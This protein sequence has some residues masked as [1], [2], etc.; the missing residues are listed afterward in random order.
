MDKK[1]KV[2]FPK[3]SIDESVAFVKK[4]DSK[5]SGRAASYDEVC[6]MLGAKASSST[7]FY[8]PVSSAR[9]FGLIA[10]HNSSISVTEQ[11]MHIIHP[12]NKDIMPLKY[13]AF[14]NSEFYKNL[15]K[16]FENQTIPTEQMLA[17]IFINDYGFV[18]S[19]KN[20]AAKA[21]LK[22]LAELH[23][24]KNSRL[25][26]N[27]EEDSLGEKRTEELEL[28]TPEPIFSENTKNNT[29]SSI[30]MND[31]GGIVNHLSGQ[32]DYHLEIPFG[33]YKMKLDIPYTALDK[34]DELSL[35]KELL[36]NNLDYLI[37]KSTLKAL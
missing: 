32:S 18:K 19:N 8:W 22:S 26:I 5:F 20:R 9:Q 33:E 30:N 34:K 12:V 11:G 31:T 17:N 24:V 7:S 16:K 1:Q 6:K 15:V 27:E 35:L 25:V 23:L 21:F 14:F 4:F 2:K 29:D 36:L 10:T 3:I 37:N 13:E 28:L